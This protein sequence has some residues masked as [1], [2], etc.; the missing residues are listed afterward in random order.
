MREGGAPEWKINAV[1]DMTNLVKEYSVVCVVNLEGLP[2]KQLLKMKQ[3]L[4]EEA[5]IKMSKKSILKRALAAAKVEKLNEHL[6]GQPALLLSKTNPFK[7]SKKIQDSK[8]SAPAKEGNTMPKD[9]I[10]PAGET[11]FMPGPIVGELGKAGIAAAIEN[12]KVVI[13]KEST[14]AKEGEKINKMQA[15]AMAKLG[16]EPMEIGLNLVAAYEDGFLYTSDVLAINT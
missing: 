12:G 10:V 6:S 13:K 11:T 5:V 9:I 15:D 1:K 8:M 4:R 14:V 7:L 3:S 2:S 16:I